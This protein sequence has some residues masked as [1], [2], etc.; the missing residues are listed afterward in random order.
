MNPQQW[1]EPEAVAPW[2]K[3]PGTTSKAPPQKPPLVCSEVPW[4][5]E[6]PPWRAEMHNK[7]TDYRPWRESAARVTKVP[8]G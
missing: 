3:V 6:P 1:K 5:T 4:R 2:R 7:D 8:Y